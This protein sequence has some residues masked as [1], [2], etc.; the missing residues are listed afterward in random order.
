MLSIGLNDFPT[1]DAALQKRNVFFCWYGLHEE[2]EEVARI[3]DRLIREWI[4]GDNGS[5]IFGGSH[6]EF[7]GKAK[8]LLGFF[9]EVDFEFLRGSVGGFEYY[10]SALQ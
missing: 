9:G 4:S 3:L 7:G 1:D 10:I 8:L 6:D 2:D 5:N